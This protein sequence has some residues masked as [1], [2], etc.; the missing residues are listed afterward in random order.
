MQSHLKKQDRIVLKDC[1][2]YFRKLNRDVGRYWWKKYV[3]G[4][5][6]SNV[7]V[8]LNFSITLITAVT[9]GETASKAL[10]SNESALYLGIFALGL[11]TINTFFSPE[12]KMIEAQEALRTWGRYGVLL[13]EVRLRDMSTPHKR[14]ERRKEYASIMERVNELKRTQ[15]SDFLTDLLHICIR[16]CCIKQRERWVGSRFL[17]KWE[18]DEVSYREKNEDERYC[19]L[20]EYMKDAAWVEFEEEYYDH[21]SGLFCSFVPEISAK[22]PPAEN[23]TINLDGV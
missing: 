18:L 20:D 12:K 2:Q 22:E 19:T 1:W 6:W 9:T 10:L 3:V 23:E 17:K 7:S 11:S 15:T 14:I 8:P 13:E 5:F 4:A 16:A 21:E